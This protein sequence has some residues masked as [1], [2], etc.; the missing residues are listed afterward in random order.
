MFDNKAEA[1]RD[2]LADT[3]PAYIHSVA[4]DPRRLDPLDN[5]RVEEEGCLG[6][7]HEKKY[8]DFP[9]YPNAVFIK[10]NITPS[11]Y[12]VNL[13]G[14]LVPPTLCIERMRNEVASMR[15]I[16][17]HTSIPT[18][19]IRC[20]FEDHGRYY[21]ITDMV[22]P[23]S[24]DLGDVPEDKRAMVYAELEGYIAQMHQLTSKVMG[25]LLGDVIPPYRVCRALPINH[26]LKLRQ[27]DTPEFVFCHNDLSQSNVLV[28]ADTFKIT[29]ILDWEYSG[30]F[31]VEFEA[32]F[33]L[34]PGPSAALDGEKD[35]V[36]ELLQILEQW[37]A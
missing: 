29:A 1:D 17:K 35:D 10:R 24:I 28:D 11:E 19:N 27:A 36:G 16:Q 34:R 32:P 8:Y 37:K 23:G 13:A 6:I 9:E 14:N 4:P 25:G 30:F 15:F 21:I 5:P 18:P 3:Q 31:P 33:Y 20:A 26:V 7:T 22:G 12:L 2:E